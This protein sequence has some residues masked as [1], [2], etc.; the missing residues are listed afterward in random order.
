MESKGK[1]FQIFTRMAKKKQPNTG[2]RNEALFCFNCGTSRPKPVPLSISDMAM[3]IE[4][5]NKAHRHCAPVCKQPVNANAEHMTERGN[6]LWW[7]E[8][9]EHGLSSKTMAIHLADPFLVPI[10]PQ[11]SRKTAPV[12]P[13]D[14]KRCE[15]LLQAVPQFRQRLGQMKQAGPVWRNLVENWDTL[16]T[17]LDEQ[18]QGKQNNMY[19]F[20]KELGC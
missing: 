13:D 8:Y 16:R 7:L 17:M 6:I 9:G 14:F 11:P 20:M 15:W 1:R 12:D 2:F 5:F 4:H 18:L 19:E 3:M 10:L